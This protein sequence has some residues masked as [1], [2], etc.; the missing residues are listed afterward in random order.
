MRTVAVP[1]RGARYR[2]G[3]AAEQSPAPATLRKALAPAT[4]RG[5]K[6]RR[7][8]EAGL[9]AARL[10]AGGA[11]DETALRARGL[12]P[13]ARRKNLHSPRPQLLH[14]GSVPSILA[15]GTARSSTR[16]SAAEHHSEHRK[17]KRATLHCAARARA[18]QL[19]ALGREVLN[20]SRLGSGAHA[21]EGVGFCCAFEGHEVVAIV[22]SDWVW[23]GG[24]VLPSEN[25]QLC[26]LGHLLEGVEGLCELS[27][28]WLCWM[29][30][31]WW[32]AHHSGIPCFSIRQY[33][34]V[35]C[36]ASWPW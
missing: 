35:P 29:L 31:S 10:P 2:H 28:L 12:P 32:G 20:W 8:K 17:K 21:R 9:G 5:L 36:W 4:G 13:A 16:T 23:W 15:S 1:H 11:E 30:S 27:A 25:E 18:Q 34:Q 22:V 3:R 33:R 26:F 6:T 19:P 7:E 14:A 24:C